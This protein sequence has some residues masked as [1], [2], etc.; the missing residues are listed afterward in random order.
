MSRPRREVTIRPRNP[1]DFRDGELEKLAAGVREAL[2]AGAHR[3]ELPPPPPQGVRGVTWYEI[4]EIWTNIDPL[5]KGA[6]GAAAQRVLGKI[7]GA[8]RTWARA[9]KRRKDSNRRPT[10]ARILGPNGELL[11]AILVDETGKVTDTTAEEQRQ[12]AEWA[13]SRRPAGQAQRPKQSS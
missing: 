1:A 8:F 13:E 6:A 2:P 9:R 10:Y 3:V 5:L 12:A 4:V 11:K 7:V